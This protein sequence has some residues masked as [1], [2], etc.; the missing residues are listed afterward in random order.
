MLAG[1]APSPVPE[2]TRAA[3]GKVE[4]A[5]QVLHKDLKMSAQEEPHIE[6]CSSGTS[7]RIACTRRYWGGT[8]T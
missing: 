2:D 3:P 1:L 5:I 8:R 6:L 7:P 4:L